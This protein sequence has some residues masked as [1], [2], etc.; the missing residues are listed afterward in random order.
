VIVYIFISFFVKFI[1]KIYSNFTST[2]IAKYNISVFKR[3]KKL[4]CEQN[5]IVFHRIHPTADDRKHQAYEHPIHKYLT[6][7][8]Y[9]YVGYFYTLNL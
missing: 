3:K 8:P 4:T 5:S 7:L 6:L 2:Y 9:I 1:V